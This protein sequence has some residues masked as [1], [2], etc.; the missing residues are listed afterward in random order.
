[1]PRPRKP[2][3]CRRYRRNRIYKPQGIPLRETPVTELDADAFEALRLCDLDGLDQ[4]AAG[5]AMGVSR[6]T[7]QRLLKEAR[8]KL[9]G[10]LVRHEALS[11]LLTEEEPHAD[12]HPHPGRRRRGCR[13]P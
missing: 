3:C 13:H 4:T 5:L 10:A 2:R 12:L 8:R 6:G 1:M 7:V 9:V 11:I